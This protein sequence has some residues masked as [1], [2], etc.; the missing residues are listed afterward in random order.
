MTD[1]AKAVIRAL[2]RRTDDDFDFMYRCAG[3]RCEHSF[4]V[5]GLSPRYTFNGDL[6]NP[7]VEPA[8]AFDWGTGRCRA[9]VRD[10]MITYHND[11]THKLA[12]MTLAM[13]SFE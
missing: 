8:L 9:T 12:G 2:R 1:T 5:S 13:L 3:C 6:V 11:S 4:R 7:T 10:G